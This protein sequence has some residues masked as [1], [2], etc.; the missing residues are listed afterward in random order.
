MNVNDLAGATLGDYEIERLLGKGGMAVVYKA[1]QVSLHREVALKILSP[2]LSSQNTFVR[3]FQREAR[4]MARLDHSGIVSVYEIGEEEG[5]HFFSME[6]ID[7][8]TLE[9]F[10][11]ETGQIPEEEAVKIITRIGRAIRVAHRDRIIHRDLKPSN[12]MIDSKKRVKV[13][14]FG[15]AKVASELSRLTESGMLLGTAAYMS[16]EQCRGDRLDLR[17]DIYS[18]GVVF[19]EMLTGKTP[20]I[21]KNNF[22]LVHKIIYDEPPKIHSINP[23]VSP[24]IAAVVAKAMARDRALRYASITQLLADLSSFE[25][26][27]STRPK[28]SPKKSHPKSP[29]LVEGAYNKKNVPMAIMAS[30]FLLAALGIVF[31]SKYI[32]PSKESSKPNERS[33]SI[34]VENNNDSEK[35]ITPPN[36][37]ASKINSAKAQV[38]PE[39]MVYVP[40]GR[41]FMGSDLEFSNEHPKRNVHLE[42]YYI[43]KQEVSN[44]EYKK[45]IDAT[46]HPAPHIEAS[47]A[48]PF[49][50][51]DGMYPKG[52]DNHP[53]VLVT[54]EDAKTYAEWAGKRLPTEAEWEKAARGNADDQQW[55][56]GNDWNDKNCNFHKA[57]TDYSKPVDAFPQ[58]ASPFGCI[59]MAG[60]AAEWTSDWYS[61]N[62]YRTAPFRNPQGPFTGESKVVRGGDWTNPKEKTRTSSRDHFEPHGGAATIGFR[63]A[64]DIKNE[65]QIV[66]NNAEK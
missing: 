2:T 27:L 28:P 21:S 12:I 5:Y 64:K 23:D 48:E 8:C 16:P 57:L 58:G 37:D 15:L 43:D 42:A 1:R 38:A 6:Y 53:V 33:S 26:P 52:K 65:E 18:L 7:G 54:W 34:I 55:P 24:K 10:M 61:E 45:F 47:W 30:L 46:G 35:P 9:Q 66:D 49:N 51:I 22:A 25:A 4:A 63:C 19:F 32:K 13:M 29:Q 44:A 11:R 50:W 40:E 59:N 41:F 14:D 60:N 62:Y 17:T 56:W 20:F 3:R 39:G 31:L 36:T